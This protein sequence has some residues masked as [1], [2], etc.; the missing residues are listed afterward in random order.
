PAG[1]VRIESL[2]HAC[3]RLTADDGTR[4]LIDPYSSRYWLQMRF[5]WIGTDH[6]IVTHDH[7]DHDAIG[8][9][10]GAPRVISFEDSKAASADPFELHA[11]VTPHDR[12]YGELDNLVVRITVAGV[13][14]V[15]LGDVQAPLAND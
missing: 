5:P 3:F 12:R 7:P 13:S 14:F 9:V 4:L 2:G 8:E 6:V 15:H 10:L 11:F 1:S